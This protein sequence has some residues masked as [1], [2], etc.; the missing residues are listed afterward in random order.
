M[1]EGVAVDAAGDI[2]VA[3]AYN[4][5]SEVVAG[6]VSVITVSKAST[7]VSLS[8]S[9][10]TVNAQSVTLTATVSVVA[11]NTGTPTG[12][13]DF[14]DSTTSTDLGTARVVNGVAAVSTSVFIAGPHMLE[15]VYSGDANFTGSSASLAASSTL[16]TA[17]GTG[18]SGYSGDGG[19]AASAELSQTGGAAADDDEDV[20]KAST[21]V[22][23]S[24]SGPTVY[25]QSVTLTATVSVVAPNTG[26]PTGTVEFYDT[27]TNTDLG[28]ASLN[29][30]G[31][32]TLSTSLLV[33]GPNALEAVY[34]GDANFAGSSTSWSTITTVAG[35]GTGGYSG[36][37]G[38]AASAELAEPWGVAVDAAGDI[39]IADAANNVV[40]EVDRATG[41]ITTVVGTGTAGYSGDN[42]AA[43]NAE[44]D[45]PCGVAVD[46]AGNLF[47]ADTFNNVIREVNLTGNTESL[48]GGIITLPAG[49]ITTVAGNGT[50]GSIGDGGS[51]TDAEVDNPRG[52]AVDA[53]GN[54]FI[55]D[56]LNDVIREVN[57]TGSAESIFDGLISLPAWD[58]TTVAGNGIPGFSGDGGSATDAQLGRPRGVAVDAEGNIFIADTNNSRIREVNNSSGQITTF[59]G[60]GALTY[61]G[62]GGLPTNAQLYVPWGV[63]VDGV[64]DVFIADTDNNCI[65]EVSQ[66]T[67]LINTI[68]GIG[69][70]AGGY[71]GDGGPPTAAQLDMPRGVAV[72]AAGDIFIADTGNNVVREAVNGV[73]V[74]P[75]STAVSLSASAAT[76][77]GQS[78][79]LTAT[80]SVVAPGAGAP[81]GTVDFIDS[82]TNTDLGTAY[83]VNGVAAIS[84]SVLV[85]GPHTLEAVYS[86]DANFAGSSASLTASSIIT[87]VAGTGTAG[88]T[89]DGGLA[90]AAELTLP[91]GTA[92]DAAGDIFIADT[93]NSRIR[94]VNHATGIITTVAGTGTAGISGDGGAATNAELNRPYGVAVDAAGNLFIADTWNNRIRVVNLTGSAEVING[95]SLAAGDIT[96][97]AGI[98]MA[99][100]SGDGGAATAA[101]LSHPEGVAVDAAGNLFIADTLNNRIRE[102]NLTGSAESI[103]GGVIN[104]PA[105]DI[106]TVAGTGTAGYSGEGRAT[107][108]KL[109]YPGG[110]AVDAE[111]DIFIADTNNRRIRLVR[112]WCGLITTY[113]GTGVAGYSGDG[114]SPTNAQLSLPA[115][116]AVDRAGDVFIAD[117]GNDR[118]REVNYATGL[119]NTVAGNGTAGY[120]GDGGSPTAAQLRSPGGVAVDATGDIFIADTGNNVVREV[121]G[122]SGTVSLASTAVSLTAAY[123]TSITLTATVSAVAPGSGEPTGTVDFIDWTTSTYLGCEVGLNGSGVAEINPSSLPPSDVVVAVYSG[124]ANFA[125]SDSTPAT[126]AIVLGDNVTL[127]V[128]LAGGNTRTLSGISGSGALDKTGGGTLI[129]TGTDTYSEGTTI[130]GGTLQ[131]GNGGVSGSL[132]SGSV[133]ISDDCSL[134]FDRSDNLTVS[135]TIS[136]EDGSVIQEGGGTVTLSGDNSDFSSGSTTVSAGVLEAQTLASLPGYLCSSS[137]GNTVSV[138]PGA[139]LAVAV[140]G[141]GEWNSG[142]TDDIAALLDGGVTYCT[143]TFE[144][145]SLLGIDTSD[146]GSGFPYGT[147]IADPSGEHLG[148]A[149]LGSN[150]LILTGDN[151]YTG[152]TEIDGGVL[153]ISSNSNLVAASNPITINSGGTLRTTANV[154]LSQEL[155]VG[156]GANLNVS[157]DTEL[158]YIGTLTDAPGTEGSLN[159]IGGGTF[160]LQA[161]ATCQIAGDLVASAGTLELDT[162]PAGGVLYNGGSVTSSNYLPCWWEVSI[163]PSDISG[164][165]TLSSGQLV[166][167]QERVFAPDLEAAVRAAVTGSVQAEGSDKSAKFSTAT[168]RGGNISGNGGFDIGNG[169]QLASWYT[170]DRNRGLNSD[171]EYIAFDAS[172]NGSYNGFFWD[173]VGNRGY[174]YPNFGPTPSR[175]CCQDSLINAFDSNSG[176]PVSPGGGNG[177]TSIVP[178]DGETSVAPVRFTNGEIRATFDDLGTGAVNRSYDNTFAGQ[179]DSGNGFGWQNPQAPSLVQTQGATPGEIA[180]VAMFDSVQAYWFDIANN[181]NTF[182]S[183]Y[184]GGQETMTHDPGNGLFILTMPDGTQYEFH[185]FAQTAAP[186]GSLKEVVLP[187]GETLQSYYDSNGRLSSIVDQLPASTQPYEQELYSYINDA[188]ADP[189]SAN[190]GEV[191]TITLQ[192]WDGSWQTE[193][194]V[195]Y[196]YYVTDP[197]T[198]TNP[199]NFNGLTG[200]LETATINYRFVSGLPTDAGDTYYYRYYINETP[201]GSCTPILSPGGLKLELLPAEYAA[202]CTA[203]GGP[204]NLYAASDAAINQYTSYLYTY[205]SSNRVKTE[206]DFDQSQYYTYS[207]YPSGHIPNIGA[208]TLAD[209]NSWTVKTIEYGADG[210]TGTNGSSYTVYTNFLGQVLLGDLVDNTPGAASPQITY[211][212]YDGNGNLILSAQPSAI[213]TYTDSSGAI[214]VTAN[215]TGPVQEYAYYPDPPPTGGAPGYLESVSIADGV[216]GSPVLQESYTYASNTVEINN[217]SV[218]VYAVHADTTYTTPTSTLTSTDAPGTPTTGYLY[219]WNG[220]QEQSV[221]MTLPVVYNGQ[222]ETPDQNGSGVA[223][224]TFDVYDQD[225]NPTWQ[226]DALGRVTYSYYDPTNGNLLY[227]IQDISYATATSPGFPASIPGGWHLPTDGISARTD[228][229]YDGLGRVTQVLG[230]GHSADIDD[231]STPVRT[232]TWTVYDDADHQTITAQGYATYTDTTYATLAGYTLVNPVSITITDADDRVADQIRATVIQITGSV[233]W[234][235]TTDTEIPFS[236][237]TGVSPVDALETVGE[238]YQPAVYP[239]S[240]YY[241][242]QSSFVAWTHNEYQE[243]RLAATGVY[244]LI[245]SSTTLD[246][247]GFAG[248]QASNYD[249]TQYGYEN[250]DNLGGLPLQGQLNMVKSPD[251]IITRYVVDDSGNVASAYVGTDDAGASDAH[252]DGS[253]RVG[254]ISG[255]TW[256]VGTG[257]PYNP[258]GTSLCFDGSA[259]VTA[260]RDDSYNAAGLT[261]LMWVKL[262]GTQSSA[263]T[264]LD[265]HVFGNT[266]VGGYRLWIDSNGYLNWEVDGLSRSIVS[267][268]AITDNDWH[269]VGAEYNPASGQLAVFIDG[270][271]TSANVTGT[272]VWQSDASA[273]MFLG[274]SADSSTGL[275]GSLSNVCFYRQVLSSAQ[276]SALYPATQASAL[277]SPSPIAHWRLDKGSGTSVSGAGYDNMVEVSSS[278]YD[279][280]GDV[281]SST[282]YVQ[283]HRG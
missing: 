190:N 101:E 188:A 282:Q 75:A 49:D 178:G 129:L 54:L 147:V 227:T 107:A 114:G 96:T 74:S 277:D 100:H 239:S 235:S 252:P 169:G 184:D 251:G 268:S 38:P 59:A 223:A 141:S 205:D 15:A 156:P 244:F 40:R 10:T 226:M 143:V 47:I 219:A 248:T 52:V 278:T 182:K 149:K 86:G 216:N 33:A 263:Y 102:V 254:A 201:D 174:C 41:D 138:S 187:G 124:D 142:I 62:D 130:S 139:T 53:A 186:R 170:G 197:D 99:G 207:Y 164:S 167:T 253:D 276:I 2:F 121:E 39:F 51:A 150:A 67:G 106:N 6:S 222:D 177:S 270:V 171:Q 94:E 220:V 154:T 168:S 191:S 29:N 267:T 85:A 181:T 152:G 92:V 45:M 122:Q 274:N 108:V 247:N 204:S 221:T 91:R 90:N 79:T 218:T 245:P 20:S 136:G 260:A 1:P 84:T 206:T 271:M 78:V 132:G 82:T 98:G 159:Q 213:S 68:A 162:A 56:T 44:L 128:D 193:Q 273:Y 95:I 176:A 19:S 137:P 113:A 36:D 192:Q 26:T 21:A 43:T 246:N 148:L 111:G 189:A 105:W 110:V 234:G 275:Q 120:S 203:L 232:A 14:I 214:S 4:S 133:D 8:A 50:M 231:T 140:G 103:F 7:A 34:G 93:T 60:T 280:D 76:V 237:P 217:V 180:I 72:D 257:N 11:P 243:T 73:T 202:A 229:Q 151:T 16:T 183:L 238:F 172:D 160:D 104:L 35:N 77:Y 161:Q 255:A 3:D 242:Y 163:S 119:I 127:N 70:E 23:L 157:N 5:V 261:V 71:S 173:V 158:D 25:G 241:P 262:D 165:A 230:P 212:K 279:G 65:R 264:L 80:V 89:G 32:A 46:A 30:N 13:V 185:D 97:V 233:T 125:G 153:S 18:T 155:A 123:G 179:N 63:A 166:V 259:S 145:D 225:G 66:S 250:F 281:T 134:V 135:N 69:T 240:A 9:S 55:A 131:I 115:G 194:M 64:G 22:S 175:P 12:T 258:A 117:T 24:A 27:T 215:A 283:R 61:G 28:P 196:G 208:P 57:L 31:V 236:L 87:T 272:P 200:D 198:Y 256:N 249:L 199:E 112:W 88:S 126:E 118:I 83:V 224:Q 48:F 269:L 146:A 266:N 58:I 144:N 42:G 81:T 265:T 209:Y 195:T 37:G 210:S 109:N 228:Y 17:A 116:V 211:N